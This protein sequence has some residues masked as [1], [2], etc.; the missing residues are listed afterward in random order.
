MWLFT[1]L[2]VILNMLSR[3]QP[4]HNKGKPF[5]IRVFTITN[6]KLIVLHLLPFLNTA[7]FKL[8]TRHTS[9]PWNIFYTKYLA[10]DFN[11]I[12]VLLLA[13]GST[14]FFNAA[15][16]AKRNIQNARWL[17][18]IYIKAVKKMTKCSPWTIHCDNI[19]VFS[20]LPYYINN[21]IGSH[22]ILKYIKF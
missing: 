1:W 2:V 15:D 10:K 7:Q 22:A 20:P 17:L 3:K 16:D 8:V 18:H 5:G 12:W 21:N 14:N 19:A 13:W 9:Q 6:N 11:P 4:I